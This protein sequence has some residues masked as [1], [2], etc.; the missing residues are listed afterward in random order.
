MSVAARKGDSVRT[1]C[2]DPQT[3]RLWCQLVNERASSAFHSPAWM[4]VL[5]ETYHLDV[6]AIVLLDELGRPRAGMPFCRISDIMGE[7]VVSLPFSDYCD[8]FVGGADDWSRLVDGL[9]AEGCPISIRC[10][11]S[12]LPCADDRF[13][14]VKQARW[15]GADLRA[16]LASLWRGLHDSSRRAVQ[17][18]QRQGVVV[19]LARDTEELR[20]F[21]DM[22]LRVRKYKYH[23][24]AQPYAFFERIW[25]HFVA[26]GR[27]AL[28]LAIHEDR[29]ISGVMLLEWQD[30]LY[31]KFNASVPATLACRPN[32]LLMWETIRYG[33][34]RGCSQLDLGL[35]DW[36][37]EGLIRYKR[38]FATCEGVISSVLHSP[39]TEQLRQQREMRSMFGRLTNAF[40]D[41]S[42]PDEVSKTAGELLY[43]F[44]A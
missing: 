42:V 13:T 26:E 4:R 12:R 33:K 8:P 37:Q 17:K 15:H 19:R 32:D 1:V 43:R 14:L 27:G 10:L 11:H 24:L 23:L 39:D 44:L 30:V 29:I 18:A 38:K 40:T 21:H 2:V 25:R 9:L 35:S 22:H 36:D 5:A 31:Y 20:A 41:E 7:R 16:D 3:D 6:R 28:L 34:A